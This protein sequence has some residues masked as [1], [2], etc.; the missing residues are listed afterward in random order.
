[1]KHTSGVSLLTLLLA[2]QAWPVLAADNLAVFD[3]GIGSQPLA[4]INSVT[5]ANTV[6]G[7]APGGRP[8]V[9]RTLKATVKAD[10]RVSVKGEG[11]VLAGGDTV[12]TRGGVGQVA[13]TFFCGGTV[14]SSAAV[15][16][17]VNGDFRIKGMLTPPPPESC[18]TAV[19]VLLIRN[20]PGGTPGAWFAA[21]IPVV[22]DA[23]DE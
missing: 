15:P 5:A 1:M 19:P 23:D 3:G 22:P 4:T 20:A 17:A 16:L 10:G 6:L 12:G 18:G 9:I 13:A 2:A 14:S 21:G 11:L 7:V 8:W